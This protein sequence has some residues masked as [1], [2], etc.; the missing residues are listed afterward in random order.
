MRFCVDRMVQDEVTGAY[1]RS[2]APVKLVSR[3]SSM[4]SLPQETRV[5]VEGNHSEMVKFLSAADLAYRVLVQQIRRCTERPVTPEC[6][7]MYL[8][9]SI[10]PELIGTVIQALPA[11]LVHS[12]VGD[13]VVRVVSLISIGR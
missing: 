6:T 4:L 3:G 1:T 5:P 7:Y 13:L 8:R 10:V 12:V 11:A 9:A 2:G